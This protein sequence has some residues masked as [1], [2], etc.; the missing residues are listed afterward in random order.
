MGIQYVRTVEYNYGAK[1]GETDFKK[2]AHALQKAGVKICPM[3]EDTKNI[4]YGYETIET[5][6]GGYAVNQGEKQICLFNYRS[7]ADIMVAGLQSFE[8]FE[9]LEIAYA[10]E[11][12]TR[13]D[14]KPVKGVSLKIDSSIIKLEGDQSD[15]WDRPIRYH[16][17]DYSSS[18][19]TVAVEVKL[20]NSNRGLILKFKTIWKPETIQRKDTLE[21][22]MV[23]L[24]LLDMAKIQ[25]VIESKLKLK[26]FGSW[27]VDEA[28]INCKF[29]ALTASSSECTP[30]IIQ[31]VRDAKNNL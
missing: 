14:W 18:S 9:N 21:R 23:D 24:P 8:G 12:T 3:F 30:D 10:S 6:K 15:Y 28:E 27:A 22:T 5:E 19:D 16:L 17:E 1:M 31:K 29:D 25:K 2:F 11:V 7:S 13:K 20:D 26:K 4:N